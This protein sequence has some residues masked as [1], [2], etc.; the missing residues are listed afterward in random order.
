[1][2]LYKSKHLRL[3]LF[4]ELIELQALKQIYWKRP[5]YYSNISAKP[6]NK[7]THHDLNMSNFDSLIVRENLFLEYVNCRHGAMMERMSGIVWVGKKL[8]LRGCNHPHSS[9]GWSVR[10]R[11]TTIWWLD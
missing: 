4:Y 11:D 2:Y 1:M 8:L 5:K 10:R 3:S 7:Q 6:T 9:Q